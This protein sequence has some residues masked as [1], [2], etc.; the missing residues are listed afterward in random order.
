M[1]VPVAEASGTDEAFLDSVAA[2]CAGLPAP[3]A[4][5]PPPVS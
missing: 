2:A 3:A 4:S 5:W 1:A